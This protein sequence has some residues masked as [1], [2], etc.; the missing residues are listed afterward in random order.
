M[1]TSDE[2]LLQL[3][4]IGAADLAK[5]LEK[6]ADSLDALSASEKTL[7][8]N[9]EQVAQSFGKLRTAGRGLTELGRGFDVLG[10]LFNNDSLRKL[11]DYSRGIGEITRSFGDLKN[12]ASQ[13]SQGGLLGKLTLG[14]GAALGGAALGSQIY[15]ATIG[16]LQGTDTATI[17]SQIQQLI[18][19]GFNVDTLRVQA[20]QA[21][22]QA[23]QAGEFGALQKELSDIG[24]SRLDKLGFYTGPKT[25]EGMTQALKVVEE[26]LK[27]APEWKPAAPG[28]AEQLNYKL[29]A[30]VMAMGLREEL[31]KAQAVE[32]Q[33]K[34][35]QVNKEQAQARL[36]GMGQI[37]TT[38]GSLGQLDQQIRALNAKREGN[39]IA[40]GLRMAA[41]ERDAQQQRAQV[42]K[43]YANDLAAM[44]QA[45]YANRLKV[46][47]QY[48]LETARMEQDHQ[49]QM[50]RMQQDH[51]L[52]LKKLADSRDA[53][54]ISDEMQAYRLERDRAE[55]DYQIQAQRR[56]ADFALQLR[57]MEESFRSQRDLRT[58]QYRD[59]LTQINQQA[60]DRRTVET[61]QW[62]LLLQTIVTQTTTAITALNQEFAKL[63]TPA[64][65]SNSLQNYG[66][67]VSSHAWGGYQAYTGAAYM[68]AGEFVLNAQTAR[69]M[70]AVTGQRL[71]QGSV[72]G[73]AMG[74]SNVNVSIP[75][76]VNGAQ[77]QPEVFRTIVHDELTK[78]MREA[79]R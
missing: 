68:H 43:S 7:V 34:M 38:I 28:E 11:G 61:Q 24:K 10:G 73:A 78:I 18:A 70:E 63:Q 14:A 67:G 36:S 3:R 20:T 9:S 60:Q 1:T 6:T 76:T 45:Y 71:S 2:L 19:A 44:E 12:V 35:Q 50:R 65:T 77:A 55:E 31:A 57:D 27:T 48:G 72:L 8:K 23:Q 56:S 29:I 53:L 54:G 21:F 42:A 13:L 16:K 58:Q 5:S 33:K 79:M 25:V 49:L 74:G 32:D 62:Q 75:L 66:G 52:R 22:I 46:A 37:G 40:H 64:A 4:E 15:D 41:I 26:Y 59:Q 39:E 69:A 47:E 51:G 30:Q 17:L